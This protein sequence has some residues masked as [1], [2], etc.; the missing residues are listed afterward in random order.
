MQDTFAAIFDM[1]GVL[2]DSYHA[3]YRSWRAMA[4]ARGLDISEEVFAATFGRTSREVIAAV[5]PELNL[6]PV[7]IA[8]MDAEK[9]RRFREIVADELPVMP[10]A[11]ELLQALRAAGAR[12]AIGSSAPRE[13]IVL[14]LEG[15]QWQGLFDAVVTGDEVTRGKPDPQVF[16]LA[17]ER[18]QVPPPCCVVIEDASQ[19][20]AAARAGGMKCIGLASTGRTRQSLAAA[21]RV[22]DSLRELKPDSIRALLSSTSSA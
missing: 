7:Q 8:A 13:N 15:L 11:A 16:L 1:D 21:D 12:L 6:T 10:G 4:Q 9:E 18:L 17:A 3:H 2:I 20:I 14:V 5:W 19:G 22:V